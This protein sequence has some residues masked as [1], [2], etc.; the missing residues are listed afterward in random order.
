M[1]EMINE[2]SCSYWINCVSRRNVINVHVLLYECNL[3]VIDEINEN[4]E[5]HQL[6]VHL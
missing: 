2:E 6:C 3:W 1:L 4:F 5:A